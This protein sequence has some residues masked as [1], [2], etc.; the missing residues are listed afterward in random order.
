MKSVPIVLGCLMIVLLC[1]LVFQVIQSHSN[2]SDSDILIPPVQLRRM[3]KQEN[4]TNSKTYD[5]NNAPDVTNPPAGQRNQTDVM[6]Q[7][8][9]LSDRG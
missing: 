1:L 6:I 8:H 4:A 2:I 9:V 3:S 7:I 5:V